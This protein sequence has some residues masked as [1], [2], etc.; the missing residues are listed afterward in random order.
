MLILVTCILPPQGVLPCAFLLGSVKREFMEITSP[1]AEL[2]QSVR[3]SLKMWERAWWGQQKQA[4]LPVAPSSCLTWSWGGWTGYFLV[5][6]TF[7]VHDSI[8]S[9]PPPIM[10]KGSPVHPQKGQNVLGV[11][12]WNL[13]DARTVC[14]DSPEAENTRWQPPSASPVARRDSTK[15][16]LTVMC[17]CVRMCMYVFCVIFL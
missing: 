4:A 5:S 11:R 7:R 3:Y 13:E 12:L 1:P 15:S 14:S 16:P 17:T 8:I 2:W 6:I 9:A 10:R